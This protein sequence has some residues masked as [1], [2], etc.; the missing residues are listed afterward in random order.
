MQLLL[1]WLIRVDNGVDDD[2]DN[3]V[4]DAVVHFVDAVVDESVGEDIEAVRGE[5]NGPAHQVPTAA[6]MSGRNLPELHFTVIVPAC[7]LVEVE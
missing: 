3:K 4:I 5:G 1:K 6:Q 7:L 2:V